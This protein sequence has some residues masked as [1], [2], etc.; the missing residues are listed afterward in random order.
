MRRA[1]LIIV[2][3]IVVVPAQALQATAQGLLHKQQHAAGAGMAMMRPL[4]A[5][6]SAMAVTAAGTVSSADGAPIAMIAAIPTSPPAGGGVPGAVGGAPGAMPICIAM[7]AALDGAPL[8]AVPMPM[9]AIG[10]IDYP[11]IPPG[12]AP[13]GTVSVGGW[14]D[15]S[16][17]PPFV[18][19]G[20]FASA[21]PGIRHQGHGPLM[22]S[23][24]GG[25]GRGTATAMS[26]NALGQTNAAAMA[27][28]APG[29]AV[30]AGLPVR[31]VGVR[32]GTLDVPGRRHMA[33][34]GPSGPEASPAG[35]RPDAGVI[36]AAGTATK[37]DGISH[38]VG[39]AAPAAAAAVPAAPP[40][41]RDRLRF[42]WPTTK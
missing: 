3:A 30:A 35:T 33:P 24:A 42:A 8:D 41:W 15:A 12:F 36:Q 9:P 40:R 29:R 20:G 6:A 16:G 17:P 25:N 13:G 10:C 21:S 19:P 32:P 26:A 38:A 34:I 23:P 39:R 28:A 37:H 22:Y 4:P 5:Q 2:A 27:S 7:P 11:C 14:P 18:A 1:S 31:A